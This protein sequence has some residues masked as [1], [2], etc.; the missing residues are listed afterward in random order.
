AGTHGVHNVRLDVFISAFQVGTHGVHNVRL[1]AMTLPRFTVERTDKPRRTSCIW[2][3]E[4]D[5]GRKYQ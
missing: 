2:G 5:T 3:T 4:W 1:Y